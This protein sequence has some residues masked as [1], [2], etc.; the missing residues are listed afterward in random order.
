ME[1]AR[2]TVAVAGE[3][4]DLIPRFLA[5]RRLEVAQ[6]GAAAARG[7]FEAA[8]RIGHTL[9]GVGG[10]YGFDEITRLGAAIESSARNGGGEVAALA[11]ELAD[12][13]DRVEITF[14]P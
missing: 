12:Y 2:R 13:L 8:R 10:G 1:S 3:L 7:D 9:K 14:T 5:N 4:R 6:L 11:R